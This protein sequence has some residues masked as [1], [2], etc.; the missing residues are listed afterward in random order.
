MWNR[1][2]RAFLTGV[3]VLTLCPAGGAQK[4]PASRNDN[5]GIIYGTDHAFTLVAPSGWVL[6]NSSGVSEGLHAVFYPEGSSWKRSQVVMYAN[7]VHKGTTD[8][9]PARSIIG[10]DIS[11]FKRRSKAPAVSD[12][13]PLTTKQNKKAVVKGFVDAP[14]G[15]YEF[16]AYIDEPRVVVL[17][18][19]SARSKEEAARAMP[20]FRELVAS[21]VFLTSDVRERP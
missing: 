10:D 7:T 13:P 14:R 6:D 19:L 18:V 2:L 4:E 9:K 3:V 21:Y 15:V 16:V 5:A 17:L 1:A 8:T 11:E 12:G 20:A